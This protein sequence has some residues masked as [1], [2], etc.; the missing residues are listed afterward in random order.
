MKKSVLLSLALTSLVVAPSFAVNSTAVASEAENSSESSMAD[1]SVSLSEGSVS[2]S[3]VPAQSIDIIGCVVDSLTQEGEPMATLRV[4]KAGV[5]QENSKAAAMGT[6]DVNGKFNLTLK[7]KGQYTLLITSIGRTP[8]TKEFTVTSGQ[9]SVDLGRFE[10]SESAQSLEDVVVAVQKPLIKVEGDMIAYSVNDDPDAKTNTLLEMLRKVPMVTVDGE[11]NIQVNGSS[12]FQ[13]FMN[14]KP[15]PMLSG[16][17]KDVLKAIPAQSIKHIEV[18]TNPGAKYDAEGVGGILNFLTDQKQGMEGYTGSVALQSGNRVNGGNA[19]VMVQKDKL[20]LS[21]NASEMY[22]NTPAVDATTVRHNL[23]AGST[24]TSNTTTSGGNNMVFATVDANYQIDEH[25]TVSATVSLM[26]MN[27]KNDMEMTTS[28]VPGSDYSQTNNNK[29]SS[30]SINASVDYMHTYEDNPRHTLTAA[31][32]YSTSPRKND[33]LTEY[34]GIEMPDYDRV[35]KNNMQ[36]HTL[37]LD[38]VQPLS[39]TST[40]EAGGKY[41]Y[42]QS[43]SIS[44]L[45]DYEHQNSIAALYGTFSQ[46]LGKLTLKGGLRYE[47]TSQDVTYNK[48]NGEDFS[49]TYNNWV[50]NLTLTYAPTYGN[51]LSLSYNMRIS[52]PGISVLNPYRNTQDLHNVSFGNPN[53]EVET[54]HNLQLT[55]NYFSATAM[56]NASLRYSYLDNGI[57][58]YSY[59]DNNVLYSTY[60]NIGQRQ[61]T[62][63]SLFASLSLTP[64][65]RLTLNSTTSYIDLRA[66]EMG[67]KNSGLQEMAM[68][69]LQQTLPWDLKLSAMFMINTPSVTL[70]G[71]S[72]GMNMHMLGLTKTFLNDRLSI[73][74]NTVNPFHSTMKMKVTSEGAGYTN[75]SETKVSMCTVM[76][77]AT[78]R[79]GD[80]KLKQQTRRTEVESDVLEVK[81][82]S[83]QINGVFQGM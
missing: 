16:S 55:Y 38:Y 37:Q 1:A 45:L 80:L 59:L 5:K 15:S 60:G 10:I 69:N 9:K 53:L 39:M 21:V 17:P 41:V 2:M 8:I 40:F 51:N 82:S 14:G 4:W 66:S 72:A 63:L 73:G 79:F 25:N 67:Y 62:A 47:F 71:E 81:S 56:F 49:L 6:T 54:S 70:Q 13:I 33:M 58:S 12:N 68:I 30:T 75:E 43:T 52:R 61:N 36:E 7:S 29:M 18:M 22:M 31:Y 24:V 65:T 23:D 44:D 11:D 77:N 46:T 48:G 74:V 20:T 26:N 83:E 32:R 3:E 76:A 64:K 42:R 27:S 28:T 19:Y 50:P 57:E 34:E 35:D 78:Y